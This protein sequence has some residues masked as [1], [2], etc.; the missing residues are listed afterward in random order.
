[1][2]NVS[3]V[4]S[5][6]NPTTDMFAGN[7]QQANA[8]YI[9][10]PQT[11]F[12][13]QQ[14]AVAVQE[15]QQ[16][17]MQTQIQR[18]TMPLILHGLSDYNNDTSNAE[19]GGSPTD[20]RTD[21]KSGLGAGL[22]PPRGVAPDGKVDGGTSASGLAPPPSQGNPIAAAQ[23]IQGLQKSQSWI[24]G[25]AD[26]TDAGARAAYFVP[27]VTPQDAQRMRAAALSQNPALITSAAL[28]R[29]QR[30]QAQTA[31]NQQ[32]AQHMFEV[33]HAVGEGGEN[34]GAM[35]NSVAP[36][37]WAHVKAEHLPSDAD[38]NAEAIAY[39]NHV[40]QNV[41]QYTGRDIETL[42][43]GTRTDKITG[44]TI[45][46][47]R[48]QLS[49]DQ[50]STLSAKWE[51][52][53][54]RP[55]NGIDV[56]KPLWQWSFPSAHAAIMQDLSN[57]GYP[58]AQSTIGGAPKADMNDAVSAGQAKHKAA[59]AAQSTAPGPPAPT[60]APIPGGA[61]LTSNNAAIMNRGLD[62]T[63]P[64]KLSDTDPDN[65]RSYLFVPPVTGPNSLRTKDQ[66]DI[67]DNNVAD[68]R[69]LKKETST[70]TQVAALSNTYL[71]AA[72]DIMASPEGAAATGKWGNLIS[73]GAKWAGGAG[74]TQASS[75]QEL[76]KFLGNAASQQAKAVFGSNMSTA[77]VTLQKE[78]LSPNT[79]LTPDAINEMIRKNM[80]I[81]QYRKD[82]AIR[83]SGYLT[84]GGDPTKFPQWNE[85]FAPMSDAIN[86]PGGTTAATGTKAAAT[87]TYN[88]LTSGVA[89]PGGAIEGA[90]A[91]S[92]SGKAMIFSNGHWQYK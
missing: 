88:G 82:S 5:I 40:A 68:K 58:G 44:M 50:A 67:Y 69:A 65:P 4:G 1:M 39:A 31:I 66:Q 9:S 46:N 84:K 80:A 20:A 2:A 85:H 26:S 49:V 42:P 92:K 43:D 36:N 27:P 35:L 7:L 54:T 47:E 70:D 53:T 25:V 34:A 45:P 16:K 81:N 22:T 18:A 72:K 23:S 76:A 91:K 60:I 73:Q 10:G 21:D 14:T 87:S 30:V 63:N 74:I 19:P 83:A 8:N 3:S 29:E 77:E 55:V 12:T 6:G 90:E 38:E 51:A 33:M 59:I 71:Q 75:N 28:M 48:S 64:K 24:D 79:A 89:P 37:A 57:Q 15:A 17:Q 86:V 13:Q 52:P 78:E 11:Q 62:M 32:S 41:H 56:T 61:P